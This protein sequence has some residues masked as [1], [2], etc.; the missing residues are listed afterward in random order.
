M[1]IAK[2][3]YKSE[4]SGFTLIEVLIVLVI[5][6][7]LAGIA[8]PMYQATRDKARKAEALQVLSAMRQSEG[9]LF[10][11]SAR[12]ATTTTELDYDFS[13]AALAVAGQIPH[14]AYTVSTSGGGTFT[15]TATRNSVD[16]SAPAHTGDTVT[17]V[18]S[19]TV[20]GT[21]IYG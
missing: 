12:Y 8:I 19:G 10:A 3:C 15:A 5:I 7:V 6:G 1:K 4:G 18:E 11:G 2:T 16:A 21:G 17:I 9:R 14:F 13:A 20:G